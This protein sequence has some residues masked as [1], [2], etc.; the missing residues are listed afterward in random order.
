MIAACLVLLDMQTRGNGNPV[1]LLQPGEQ[2]PSV[3]AFH[4]DFPDL[5]LPSGIGHDGQQ[6]YAIARQPMHWNDVSAQLDRPQYRLQRPLL[7]WLAWVLHPQGGGTGLVWALFAVELFAFFVGGLALGALSLSLGGPA[8]LAVVFPLLPGS[9]ASG[10]II[11]ADALAA[12]LM[13]AALA[14]ALRNRW[15]GAVF[16][17]V[18]AVLA[19]ESVLIIAV[20][21]ALWRRDRRGVALAAV[22]AAVAGGLA[23]ALRVAVSATGKQ[24]QEFTYP[25][26]GLWDSLDLWTHGHEVFALATVTAA[27]V[28]GVVGLVR[29]GLRWPLGWALVIEL[30]FTIMLGVNVVGLNFNGTRTTLPLQLLV[31]LAIAVPATR[32]RA[33]AGVSE[34]AT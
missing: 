21:F 30:G 25:F 33:S 7:P 32:S 29:H 31:A 5:Q 28:L 9:V 23:I 34:L 17:A 4:T 3:T 8:W 11:G 27:L 16:V 1:S 10:R 24:V 15:I 6:F 14:L 18:A 19:K 20:G 2:G 13:T 26:G 12:A 22:P